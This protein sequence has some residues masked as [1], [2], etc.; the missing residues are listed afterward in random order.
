M[1]WDVQEKHLHVL[2]IRCIPKYMQNLVIADS[3]SH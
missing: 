1:N 2:M 3:L